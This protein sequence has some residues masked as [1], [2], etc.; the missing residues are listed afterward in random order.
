MIN[1]STHT[2][3]NG[4]RVLHH[5][6]GATRMVAVN[7]LF[8]VGSRDETPEHTGLAHLMEHLMF[9]GSKNA[10]SFD[11]ALQAAGGESNA[12]TSADITN[13]YDI[14]PAQNIET[15]LWLESDRLLNLNL[16]HQS[17]ALQKSVV[18]EEFKQR[19]LNQPYGDL[20]HLLHGAAF[21]VH[22]Y[23]W[24]TIGLNV[25]D[26]AS[27]DDEVVADFY[28]SHYAVN[29]AILCVAGNVTFDKTIALVNKWFGDIPPHEVAAR[30]LP[31]EP[32]QLSPRLVERTAPVP[33]DMIFRAYHMCSRTD[34]DFPATDLL[35]DILANGT[36]SRFYRNVVTK[37]GIFTELDA[38]V[39]GLY[40]PGLFYV[41]GRLNPGC[42]FSDA[43]KAI[44]EELEKLIAEGVTD[45]EVQK[46]TNKFLANDMFE[47]VHYVEKAAR[48]CRYELLMGANEIN[49]EVARYRAVDAGHIMN[50]AREVLRPENCTTLHYHRQ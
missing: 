49:N 32:R 29:N 43:E 12:W 1:V 21:T 27:V 30:S 35:S 7:I 25:E 45:Y 6:N 44:D 50:V 13:Y 2:L 26:I 5:Y 22:P 19:Y 10:P 38:S 17:I 18:T 39:A 31:R 48:L 14:L 15:A 23:R 20:Y 9:T 8:D 4:L 37:K 42:S 41:R 34:H 28:H 24:P 36:S 3:N 33:A 11:D 16:N 47:S 46:Y 40:D